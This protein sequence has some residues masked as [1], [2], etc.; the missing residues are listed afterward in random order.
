MNGVA[1]VAPT[2]AAMEAPSSSAEDGERAALEVL[3]R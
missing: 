2:E 1:F 3:F